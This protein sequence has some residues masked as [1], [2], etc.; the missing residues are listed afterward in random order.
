MHKMLKNCPSPHCPRN[1]RTHL[2]PPVLPHTLSVRTQ[3][4]FRKIVY[5]LRKN[6]QT[7]GSEE[8]ALPPYPQ[9][10]TPFSWL[11]TLYGQ[12]LPK[13]YLSAAFILDVQQQR[14]SYE[15]LN[16]RKRQC[17]YMGVRISGQGQTKSKLII[18]GRTI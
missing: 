17:M 16:A 9:W 7:S 8:P 5:F 2:N 4:N 13:I 11:R 10:R 3:H 6:V 1:V 12:P 15:N 18:R 14:L